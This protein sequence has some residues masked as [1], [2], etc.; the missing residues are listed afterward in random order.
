VIGERVFQIKFGNVTAI[1]GNKLTNQFDKAGEKWVVD[2]FVEGV[3]GLARTYLSSA[4]ATPSSPL[5][6][7]IRINLADTFASRQDFSTRTCVAR[8]RTGRGVRFWNGNGN[9]AEA[10]SD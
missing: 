9:G 2:S 1:D 3:K 7:K 10:F 8:R 6:P 5:S 4:D